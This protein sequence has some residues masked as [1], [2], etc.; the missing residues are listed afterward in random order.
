MN[1]KK[2]IAILETALLLITGTK[3]ADIL[4]KYDLAPHLK[5]AKEVIQ[6]IIN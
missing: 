1:N 4:L 2:Q 3:E 5:K 6:I